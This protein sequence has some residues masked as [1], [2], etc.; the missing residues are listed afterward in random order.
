M[1]I[2]LADLELDEPPAAPAAPGVGPRPGQSASLFE[3]KSVPLVQNSADLRRILALPRRPQPNGRDKVDALSAYLGRDNPACECAAK[4]RKCIRTLRPIQVAALLEIARY[5]GVLG[6]IIVGGGKTLIDLLAP[7]MLA[8]HGVKTT[9]LLVPAK[10]VA[11]IEI[12]VDLYKQHLRMPDIMFQGQN[13][14]P[15]RNPSPHGMP[16]TPLLHVMSYN[17]LQ[18]ASSTDIL[19][20]LKPDAIIADECQN[21]RAIPDGASRGST[22]AGRV[23]DYRRANPKTKFVA[24]SG[25]MTKAKL[26][27]YGH[28]ADWALANPADPADF[29]THRS[30]LPIDPNARKEWGAVIDA[31]GDV[32]AAGAL[33]ALCGPGEGVRQAFR[34]RLHDTPGVIATTEAVIDATLEIRERDVK[35]P[36]HLRS[37]IREVRD[38]W[39]RPDGEELVDA[40]SAARC[41]RE[42]ACGLYLYWYFPNGEPEALI[43]EW[44]EARKEW[45]KE[46]R[47][48]L[49]GRMPHMDSPL[50]CARAAA[51][52]W[53][54][55]TPELDAYPQTSEGAEEAELGGPVAARARPDESSTALL[56]AA[57][58]PT[59][60]AET[61]PRWAKVKG[62]VRPETRVE[63][64][65][66]YLAADAAA[67][68]RENKGI[69]WYETVGFGDWVQEISGLW[70]MPGMLPR[71]GAGGTLIDRATGDLAA[72]V[73]KGTS[74][75]LSLRSYGTGIDRLQYRYAAQLFA[76]PPSSGEAWEQALGRLF[77]DGQESPRVTADVYRCTPELAAAV[78]VAAVQAKY[79][80]ETTGQAQKLLIGWDL[81]R[82][83]GGVE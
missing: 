31:G 82:G 49:R 9:L 25:S 72:D 8:R 74:V 55:A 24:L 28:F 67:W 71:H 26:D 66:D 6:P 5:G 2:D 65:D 76:Q 7:W 40:L 39:I 29:D 27:D 14:Q 79:V 32:S 80:E 1:P 4:G 21:I 22:R 46:L 77:R 47:E 68:G 38:S 75:I 10:L 60:K 83:P 70:H 12:D 52:A 30:P 43:K 41:L 45:H 19:D 17:R 20:R 54:T 42:L 53:G 37:M 59:W 78:D 16:S 61:W 23:Y 56:A 44:L 62:R 13:D 33:L 15:H 58:L 81:D 50:L 57:Q 11:Q 73:H 63:R 35:V 36:A 34:R 18:V 64:V 48:V 69:V 51:R 3:S